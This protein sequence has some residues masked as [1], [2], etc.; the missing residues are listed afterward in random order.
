[1][2]HVILI[3]ASSPNPWQMIPYW[4]SNQPLPTRM[5]G[6]SY[7]ARKKWNRHSKDW[8]QTNNDTYSY[9]W[10]SPENLLHD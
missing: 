10:K 6:I 3:P 1:M 9:N 2:N 8:H 7:R 5:S 4:H